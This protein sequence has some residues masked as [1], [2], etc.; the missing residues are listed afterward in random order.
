VKP[1]AS[2]GERLM[3]KTFP[4]GQVLTAL[5]GTLLCDIDGLYAVHNFLTGQSLYTHQ[6]P[7]AFRICAPFVAEQHPDLAALDWSGVNRKNCRKW[8][9]VQVRRFGPTRELSPLPAGAYEA[10]HPLDELVEMRGS[11][12]GIIVVDGSH[13]EAS[14]PAK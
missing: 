8:L 1:E 13:D 4:L 5:T 12:D 11:S 3:K 9:Q 14:G 2:S 10:M 7:R 6:L